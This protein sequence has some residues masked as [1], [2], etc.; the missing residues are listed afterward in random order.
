MRTR[1]RV[2]HAAREGIGFA[3]CDRGGDQGEPMFRTF[4]VLATLA[5]AVCL[6]SCG[7]GSS[8]TPTA[9]S[10]P[11]PMMITI[12]ARNGALSFSPNPASAGGQ[13]VVF[14][15]GDAIVHRVQLNDATVDTG[16]IGP[17]STSR[18]VQMPSSGTN[19]HCTL[20]PDMIGAVSTSAGAPP[21]PCEGVYCDK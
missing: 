4:K 12:V 13:M 19:Y 16:D 5:S 2:F 10:N 21:P 3:H 6:S 15:N 14:R 1:T 9:P 8:S 18:A 20:H 7:G 11:T 17:G